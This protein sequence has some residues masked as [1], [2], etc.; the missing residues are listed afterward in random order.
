MTQLNWKLLTKKRDSS[1]Q[2]LPPGNEHLAWV[3]N[4][5]TFIYGE[6]E[7]VLVDTFL[8]VQHSTEL[9]NWVVERQECYDHLHHPCTR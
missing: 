4:T 3:A 6:R 9:V 8:S 2:G 7:A 5:V 1:T